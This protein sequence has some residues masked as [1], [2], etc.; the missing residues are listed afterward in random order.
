LPFASDAAW[1]CAAAA[2]LAAGGGVGCVAGSGAGCGDGLFGAAASSNC[3][4]GV[5]GGPPAGAGDDGP[6]AGP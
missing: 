6:W 4:N 5:A 2:L 1:A 3:E